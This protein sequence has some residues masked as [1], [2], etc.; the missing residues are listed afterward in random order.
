MRLHAAR[1]YRT[2][3]AGTFRR[4]STYR[5][6]T[7]AGVFTNT[8]FG[9]IMAYT[10]LALW[11]VRPHL[12]GYTASDALTYVFIGQSLF[13]VV[14]VFGGGA[15]DDM[16][17]RIRS[18]DISVDLY[19]PVDLQTWWL[20]T[21]LGRA[22]FQFLARGIP[23]TVV[24]ALAFHLSLPSDP[25]VWLAFLLSAFLG[26]LVSFSVRYLVALSG[27][28]LIDTSG[29]QAAA[30]ILGMFFSGQLLPLNIF[31]G[32][33]KQIAMLLPWA[34]MQQLPIDVLL[35]TTAS[36]GGLG[37]VLALQVTWAAVLLALGRLVTA[38]AV[39]KVVFQGG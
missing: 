11:N 28:W 7:I 5:A 19:R 13:A 20:A 12:G 30:G 37:G 18:G 26:L 23:P 29:T 1:L 31:P 39:R 36:L 32:A 10:Y 38:T 9:F 4:Y 25:L 3:A 35:R 21:D 24:G 8:V 6:A 2:V 22:A 14:A 15:T 27:F 16:I 17:G 34:G 33:L